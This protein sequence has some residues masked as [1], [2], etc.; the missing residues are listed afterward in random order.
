MA[1][2]GFDAGVEP[3][4]L[5][6]KN[7]VKIL[8]CYLLKNVGR[9]LTFENLNEILRQDGLVNYFEFAQAVKEMLETGHIDLI[10]QGG[11]QAYKVTKL[12]AGTAGLFERRLP[13]SVRE[14]AVRSGVRL[15]AKIQ[16]EAENRA[17]IIEEESGGFSVRCRI[18]DNGDEL[19]GITLL[20]PALDQARAVQKEFQQNPEAVYKGVLA[21][22]TGNRAAF[23]EMLGQ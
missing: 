1:N 16:R 8:I 17:E 23:R 9:P 12:G 6:D 2:D 4:G 7:E 14:K 21:L 13:L 18:L 19:M 20:V 5:R 15:L 10:E 11:A 22:L 3:G